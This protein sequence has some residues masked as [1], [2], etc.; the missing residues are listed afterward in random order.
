M[1]SRLSLKNSARVALNSLILISLL[2]FSGCSSETRPTYSKE[3][4]A[5]SIQDICKKEYN[6]EIKA[7]LV[8]DTLWVYL[9]VEELLVKIH[10]MQM[11]IKDFQYQQQ[12]YL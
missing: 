6:L 9:S 12:K 8:G 2:L 7:R 3:N 10:M 4:L 11:S 1:K 5:Q